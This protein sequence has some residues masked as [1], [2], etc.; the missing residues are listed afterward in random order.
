L[1]EIYYVYPMYRNVSFTMIAEQHIEQLQKRVKIQRIPE[2]ALDNLMWLRPR[3]VILHPILYM[4]MGDRPDML[5][6][7]QERL[8][9]LMR[10]KGVMGGFETADSD[11]ISEVAVETLNQL[12]LVFLPSQFAIDCFKSSGVKVP[13]H[14]ITHGLTDTMMTESKS[15]EHPFIQDINNMKQREHVTLILYFVTH[16]EYRKGADIVAD[17]MSF[18]Q[19]KHRDVLLV[20]K[21]GTL[22]E[23][24]RLLRTVHVSYWLDENQLRQLY[25]ACDMLIVP[26]RGGGFELNALEGIVRG[27]PTLVPNAGCFKEILDFA[28]PL[29]ITGNPKVFK[30]NPIHVG[31]GWETNADH[32]AH[33]IDLTLSKLGDWKEKFQEHS[34]T[35]RKVYSW[36]AV[37][38]NLFNLLVKYGFCG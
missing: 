5:K 10:V 4:T 12:D 3:N 37:C 13:I 33:S 35:V 9:R 14:K 19:Q 16:S 34:K 24:F 8:S 36:Q 27:L 11:R 20:V 31:N 15:I 28:I 2:D 26:S 21:S 6:V 18:I 17:A 29:T 25:D 22:P 30:D 1:G 38:E 32:L 23:R 7:R